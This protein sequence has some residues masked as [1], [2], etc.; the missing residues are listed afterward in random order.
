M[1]FLLKEVI[2]MRYR[3]KIPA[4]WKPLM[5]EDFLLAEGEVVIVNCISAGK[6]EIDHP[7]FGVEFVPKDWL[8]PIEDG[9]VSAGAWI[10]KY[11]SSATEPSKR[12]MFEDMVRAFKGGEINHAKRV[13]PL[14]DWAKTQNSE[15]KRIHQEPYPGL[16]KILKALEKT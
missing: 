6:A 5:R 16:N 1:I 13:K 11:S 9:P 3:L 10:G 15:Y 4:E 12:W 7:G 14:I 8:E 2:E